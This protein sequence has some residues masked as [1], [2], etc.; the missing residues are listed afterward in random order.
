[1]ANTN[2]E[3]TQNVFV[4]LHLDMAGI[5][6]LQRSSSATQHIIIVVKLNRLSGSGGGNK[7]YEYSIGIE[8]PEKRLVERSVGV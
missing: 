6:S 8:G 3:A 2:Y 7:I 4:L 5:C 1:M